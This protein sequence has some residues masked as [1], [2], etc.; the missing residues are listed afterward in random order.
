M[1]ASG[2][3]KVLQLG[4]GRRF[5]GIPPNRFRRHRFA[6]AGTETCNS[7]GRLSLFRPVVPQITLGASTKNSGKQ[8]KVR[9]NNRPDYS[10]MMLISRIWLAQLHG[11]ELRACGRVDRNP[12]SPAL[13][14]NQANCHPDVLY[15]DFP[16][17]SLGVPLN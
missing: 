17:L 7:K 12:T 14:R 4:G 1:H 13:A 10:T 2:L 6:I 9:Q 16:R 5:L 11:T 3:Y 15:N 8:P